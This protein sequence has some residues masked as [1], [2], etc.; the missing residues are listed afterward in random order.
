MKN[1]KLLFP[2][3]VLFN[4]QM[5]LADE[6]II[7]ND[8]LSPNTTFTFDNKK[9]KDLINI[10]TNLDDGISLNFYHKFN[11]PKEG[12]ILNNKEAKANIIINE[13]T[14]NEISFINGNVRVEGLK[15]HVII[16]NPNGIECHQCSA[17][18]VTDFTLISGKTN[19]SV[20]D[21]IL[22]DKNYV[23]IRGLKRISNQRINLISNKIFMEG[24]LNKSIDT[25]NILSGLQT[26]HLFSKNEFNHNGQISFFEG[27]KHHLKNVDITHGYGEIYL[28]KDIG[29]LIDK[30]SINNK[31][32]IKSKLYLGN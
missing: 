22:S 28:D 24:T 30:I 11:I 7:V 17:S 13:V 31:L 25:L 20:R 21:F 4:S 23:S 19:D 10:D 15:A 9:N 2:F 12:V 26:Y 27:F 6:N 8:I 16:A 32:E 14:G 3:F 29:N 1:K 5:V 18:R